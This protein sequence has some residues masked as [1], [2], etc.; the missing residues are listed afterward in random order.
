MDNLL[1]QAYVF[2]DVIRLGFSP[3]SKTDKKGWLY[4]YG[5]SLK[6]FWDSNDYPTA[7]SET[8][9]IVSATINSSSNVQATYEY[10]IEKHDKFTIRLIHYPSQH[11]MWTHDMDGAY[12]TFPFQ[13]FLTNHGQRAQAIHKMTDNDIGSV[14]DSLLVHPAPH[15]HIESPIDNH[16]IRIGGGIFNPFQYLFHLRIQLCPIPGRRDAERVRLI[17]LFD[18]AIRNNKSIAV[19]E[20]MKVPA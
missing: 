9:N 7:P 2:Q 4:Q 16:E 10:A 15:Q 1:V 18:N 5:K 13:T 19:N 14:I 3:A 6:A 12:F 17:Q 8:N 20:L 11:L